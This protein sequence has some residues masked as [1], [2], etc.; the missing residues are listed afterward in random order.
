MSK[1][2]EKT[3]DAGKKIMRSVFRGVPNLLTTSDLNRQIEAL[4]FQIDQL[5]DLVGVATKDFEVI[6][7]VKNG[8]LNVGL[9]NMEPVEDGCVHL[10]VKGCRFNI[11][12]DTSLKIDASIQNFVYLVLVATVKTVTYADDPTHEISGATF[13]DGTSME[14]ADNHV[15]TDEHLMLSRTI[16]EETVYVVGV[17]NV[18][19]G[20]NPHFIDYANNSQGW[21]LSERVDNATWAYKQDTSYTI[22]RVNGI[23]QS[24]QYY[25]VN[26]AI[27]RILTDLDNGVSKDF[28]GSV[29][30]IIDPQDEALMGSAIYNRVSKMVFVTA[31]LG[32]YGVQT[33]AHREVLLIKDMGKLFKVSDTTPFSI[34]TYR[35]FYG[36]KSTARNK[37]F[38]GT[39]VNVANGDITI[40][41]PAE[42]TSDLTAQVANDAS[43]LLSFWFVLG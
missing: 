4:K 21:P 16:P 1:I 35:L 8:V 29:F 11:N 13:E 41:C 17:F 39:M 2:L 10:E 3:F 15:Y 40:A 32:Y 20:K 7:E 31:E 36:T 19:Q 9:E 38:L 23:L 33:L 37:D 25:T 43:M 22:D 27:N 18:A 30:P 12:A 5:Q 34:P 14:A 28:Q 26:S 24:K 6:Y 42:T